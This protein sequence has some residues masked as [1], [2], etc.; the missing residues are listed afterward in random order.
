MPSHLRSRYSS[1]LLHLVV[2]F[3]TVL[4]LFD[5]LCVGGFGS[6]PL[7]GLA[8][9]NAPGLGLGAWAGFQLPSGAACSV[10]CTGCHRSI[11]HLS[12]HVVGLCLKEAVYRQHW[13]RRQS[14]CHGARLWTWMHRCFQY[15]L[16]SF[17][18]AWEMQ[19]NN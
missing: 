16:N 10:G 6:R 18:V 9:L 3:Q 5:A 1:K 14:L 13:D 19:V 11:G 12:A 7:E 15:C 4:S 8:V 17:A 2:L